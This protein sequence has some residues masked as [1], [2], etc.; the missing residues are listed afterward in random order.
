MRRRRRVRREPP[1][2]E[3]DPRNPDMLV[4][5]SYWVEVGPGWFEK[6][7]KWMTPEQS[8]A[9]SQASLK[10]AEQDNRNFPSWDNDPTYF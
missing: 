7:V 1:R 9:L 6:H 8:Q 4:L 10:T 5:R 3:H 2:W